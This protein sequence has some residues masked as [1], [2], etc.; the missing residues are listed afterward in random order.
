V[1][2]PEL[3][4]AI[5]AA[6]DGAIVAPMVAPSRQLSRRSVAAKLPLVLVC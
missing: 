3:L 1:Q 5:V 6:T 4:W 2:I